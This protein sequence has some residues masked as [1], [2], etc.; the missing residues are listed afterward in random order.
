MSDAS[1]KMCQRVL[2][3]ALL[4]QTDKDYH[5]VRVGFSGREAGVLQTSVYAARH[6]ICPPML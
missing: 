2:W 3:A 1:P 5:V 4:W 6:L